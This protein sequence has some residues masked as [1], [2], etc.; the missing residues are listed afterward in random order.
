MFVEWIRNLVLYHLTFLRAL[1]V[2]TIKSKEH[3]QQ[4]EVFKT[5][6]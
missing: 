6:C 4:A 3:S 2:N 5:N 1:A